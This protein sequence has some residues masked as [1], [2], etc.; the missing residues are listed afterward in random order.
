MLTTLLGPPDVVVGV[1]PPQAAKAVA[2]RSPSTGIRAFITNLPIAALLR[3]SRIVIRGNFK[4]LGVAC[5]V[6][7][8]IV[9][10]NRRRLAP[11]A[12]AL[13]L[14][15]SQAGHLLAYQLRFGGAAHQIQSTGVHAYFP[16]VA[17]TALGAVAAGLIA[18]L[19][20]GRRVRSDSEPSFISLLAIL[21]SLQLATFAAQEIVE[22]LV[23]GTSLMSAPDL[24]LWGTLGQ[25]P[26]AV[27]A[28]SALRWLSARVESAVGLIRDA[29]G[30][31]LRIA[32]AS[33]PAVPPYATP[34][35]ALLV[36]RVAGSSLAKRGPPS[37]L[38]ISSI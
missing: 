27:I 1:E 7:L 28:A 34:D 9:A 22:G 4:R 5:G 38:R 25:L 16:L 36:S 12:L 29:I 8:I 20:R 17:K 32:P 18:R 23:G 13:G 31:V 3:M 26:V 24:L 30:V 15:G 37:S 11:A 21:F 19:L 33:V 35:I 2:A 10:M 6:G 14:L